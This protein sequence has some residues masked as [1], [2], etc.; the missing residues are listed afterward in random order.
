M[1]RIVG[2][3]MAT[4]SDP[5]TSTVYISL[6]FRRK[7]ERVSISAGCLFQ[8]SV[9]RLRTGGQRGNLVEKWHNFLSRS[10]WSV[11][12]F[13]Y[14]RLAGWLCNCRSLLHSGAT[15]LYRVPSPGHHL[16][17]SKLSRLDAIDDA[18][19]ITPFTFGRH[20][21]SLIVHSISIFIS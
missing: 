16:C 2:C 5:A 17:A 15:R 14:K 6:F 18:L 4:Q 1:E 3:K 13:S 8:P 21:I 12:G 9:G 7:K 20:L 19:H 11:V 10:Y